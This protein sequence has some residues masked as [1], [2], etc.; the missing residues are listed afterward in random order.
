MQSEP[1]EYFFSLQ[2]L[3]NKYLAF[4]ATLNHYLAANPNASQKLKLLA[5]IWNHP[6]GISNLIQSIALKSNLQPLTPEDIALIGQPPKE[7]HLPP[8]PSSFEVK[9]P[10]LADLAVK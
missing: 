10:L 2:H 5:T 7:E 4:M 8:R 6:R 1:S 3:L 9:N